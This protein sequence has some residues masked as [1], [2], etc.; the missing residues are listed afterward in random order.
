M[1]FY[2]VGLLENNKLNE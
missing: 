1:S 2:Q